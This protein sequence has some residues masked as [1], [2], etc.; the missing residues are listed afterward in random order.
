[1]TDI[2]ATA[3]DVRAVYRLIL[4]REPDPIGLAEHHHWSPIRR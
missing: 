3:D 2:I 1:M 4:Q